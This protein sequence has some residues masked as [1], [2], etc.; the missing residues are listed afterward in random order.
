MVTPRGGGWG[1]R[2]REAATECGP[3]LMRLPAGPAF[4]PAPWWRALRAIQLCHTGGVHADL[5]A[6]PLLQPHPHPRRPHLCLRW[7]GSRAA[8]E[9]SAG[10]HLSV[11]FCEERN[12]R[13]AFALTLSAPPHG[14]VIAGPSGKKYRS[15]L[16]PTS[17]DN[18]VK[19]SA[20][21]PGCLA[22]VGRRGETRSRGSSRGQAALLGNLQGQGLGLAGEE[23]EAD[24]SGFRRELVSGQWLRPRHLEPDQAP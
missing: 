13:K 23:A 21:T 4:Q 18:I 11:F 19:P 8:S 2:G 20:V 3:W 5:G 9:A 22:Q 14:T 7:C 15:N 12:I 1:R 6:G 24:R 16:G 10:F 17:P